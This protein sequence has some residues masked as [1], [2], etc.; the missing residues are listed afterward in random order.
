MFQLTSNSLPSVRDTIRDFISGVDKIDLRTIDANI[1]L[2]YDQA[3]SYV[4][5]T[6]FSGKAGELNFANGVLSG[7]VN[8]DKVADFQVNITGVSSLSATDFYL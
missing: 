5:T 1:N 6:A 7:D 2:A 4:G 8:G 3:F